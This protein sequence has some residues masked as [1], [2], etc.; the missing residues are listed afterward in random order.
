M[1]KRAFKDV[2]PKK[3]WSQKWSDSEVE[4]ICEIATFLQYEESLDSLSLWRAAES[5]FAS[6]RHVTRI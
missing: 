4:D 5:E 6:D 3:K 2:P 1:K